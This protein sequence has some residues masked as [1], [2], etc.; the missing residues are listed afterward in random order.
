MELWVWG[1]VAFTVLFVGACCVE[2]GVSNKRA[3]RR[4]AFPAK[5]E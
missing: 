5:A 2:T 3:A 4:K 1:V